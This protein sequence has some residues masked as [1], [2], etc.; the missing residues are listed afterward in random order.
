MSELYRVDRLCYIEHKHRASLKGVMNDMKLY[1]YDNEESPSAGFKVLWWLKTI[2]LAIIVV[3]LLAITLWAAVIMT[4]GVFELLIG[5][6][7]NSSGQEQ[8]VP[9]P[10]GE[11]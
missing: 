1:L 2:V 3:P 8:C 10:W 11:C 7:D 9:D 4:L 5:T 6:N